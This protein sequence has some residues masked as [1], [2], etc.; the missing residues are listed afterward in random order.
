MEN[1]PTKVK[2]DPVS[3]MIGLF[4]WGFLAIAAL[5]GAAGLAILTIKWF[6]SLIKGGL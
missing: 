5:S 2:H 3:A 1:D 6:V 4:I